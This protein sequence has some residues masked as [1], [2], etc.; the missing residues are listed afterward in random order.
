[1]KPV[2][3]SNG[4]RP[5]DL[6]N[7]GGL[8][9][10]QQPYSGQ[11]IPGAPNTALM[12]PQPPLANYTLPGVI[13]Y[14]TSEFTNLER[15][16]IMTNL[17]KSELKYRLLQL[18]SEVNSLRFVNDKQALRIKELEDKVAVLEGSL[19][20]AKAAVPDI[21]IPPVDLEVLRSSRAQLNRSIKEV[22][23][24]LKPPSVLGRNIL[25]V[26]D[27]NQATTDFDELLDDSENFVFDDHD[28]SVRKATQS[29]F[30]RYSAGNDDL[31][32]GTKE[33]F[34]DAK[35]VV[36]NIQKD[37]AEDSKP[38]SRRPSVIEESDA[39][40][41]IVDEQ[42]EGILKVEE[43]DLADSKDSH[44]TLDFGSVTHI[45]AP[46]ATVY[47]PFQ[48]A[49]VCAKDSNITVWQDGT[50]VLTSTIDNV[51]DV[52]CI[53]FMERKRLLVVTKLS[54]IY[55]L[56]YRETTSPRKVMIKE[57]KLQVSCCD[58]VDLGKTGS[59]RF[60][61]LVYATCN[62][63]DKSSIFAYEI[64]AG[65]KITLKLL[66]LFNSTFIKTSSLVTSVSWIKNESLKAL[67][68]P[69]K[70]TR[71]VEEPWP[72][73][74]VLFVHRKV[75]KVNITLKEVTDVYAKAVDSLVVS[76]KYALLKEQSALLLFDLT[77]NTVVSSHSDYG[78]VPHALFVKD[79]PYVAVLHDGLQV[80]D[81]SFKHVWTGAGVGTALY[82]EPA[83]LIVKNELGIE[84]TEVNLK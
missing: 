71:L 76:G 25:D 83:G 81:N 79:S 75:S 29:I 42:D 54:G 33:N 12:L 21:E 11:N 49:V 70:S 20:S 62:K 30:T 61:G 67:K 31:L 56:D 45:S 78:A 80:Y 13:S 66:G 63:E 14:L 64:K 17:E 44:K 10:Y 73:C 69:K 39:E 65:L 82:A 47:P 6:G 40:T 48:E 41:V 60:F 38:R 74:E 5:K 18:I 57:E 34:E 43:A 1:M 37:L 50:A 36:D 46:D 23:R 27:Q 15:F 58:L 3:A 24:L 72:T 2:A 52:L 26:P 32:F 84:V 22:V 8:N 59:N 16:K 19:K 77:S 7:S 51:A 68:S 9:Q 55:V 28:A 53:Y 35:Q 4:N